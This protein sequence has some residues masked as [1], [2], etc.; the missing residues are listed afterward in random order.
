MSLFNF[1]E[2]FNSNTDFRR[3]REDNLPAW[4]SLNTENLAELF[5]GFL[6]YYAKFKFGFE[7]N[8]K[9]YEKLKQI[10]Y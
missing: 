10:F 8:I 9:L 7:I 6:N 1:K 2:R 4:S 5:A 3:L